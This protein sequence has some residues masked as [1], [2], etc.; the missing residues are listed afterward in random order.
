MLRNKV[1]NKYGG[2]CAYCGC[3]LNDKFH[4]DHLSP[5]FKGIDNSFN[6]LMP[7][8]PRCNLWKKSYSLEE[9]RKQIEMQVVRAR[10][11]SKNFRL[12][13]DFELISTT[14]KKVV[15]YFEKGSL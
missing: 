4:I 9:F 1:K 12:A 5:K 7:A 10:K 11:Y 6:N 13:E 15:F 8:C 14:G 2:K 3:S